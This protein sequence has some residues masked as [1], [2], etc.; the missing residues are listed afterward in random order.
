MNELHKVDII[1]W[2]RKTVA[3]AA[4]TVKKVNNAINIKTVK[5]K[6]NNAFNTKR[7]RKRWK[8][9]YE[10][11]NTWPEANV[12]YASKRGTCVSTQI[13]PVNCTGHPTKHRGCVLVPRT[14]LVLDH[15]T[16]SNY[17]FRRQ[18]RDD[19]HSNKKEGNFWKN[20]WQKRKRFLSLPDDITSFLMN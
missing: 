17:I 16:A 18:M 10:D 2:A 11:K 4:R 5:E 12:C 9:L 14:Q 15:G 6:M 1:S 7:S 20:W 8:T 19:K 13:S 3:N